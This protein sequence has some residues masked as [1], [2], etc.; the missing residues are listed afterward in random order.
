MPEKMLPNPIIVKVPYKRIDT[1]NVEEI[2]A[3][4]PIAKG[5]REGSVLEQAYRS[6]FSKYIEKYPTV[7]IVY[8]SLLE[9]GKNLYLSY[10]GETNNIGERTIQHLSGNFVA[11]F[12]DE[13][14]VG[15][16][17]LTDT[18]L[19]QYVI[20]NAHF[21]K[22]LTMD[23]ENKL[24]LYLSGADNV[25]RLFNARTNEQ[26]DYYTHDEFDRIFSQIWLTLHRDNP[27]LFPAE[28][29]IRD[30][31]LFK[32]SPFHE[33]TPSQLDAEQTILKVL[34][35]AH[36]GIGTQDRLTNSQQRHLILVQGGSGT[37]K[38]VL[39]SH[40]FNSV[41]SEMRSKHLDLESESGTTF[42]L[43]QGDYI[44]D[45][46]PHAYLLVNHDE[47]LNVY[48]QIADKLELQNSAN[49]RVLL[50]SQFI[51]RI[52]PICADS[53]VEGAD[54]VLVDEAHLLL[55]QGSQ[56]YRGHNMLLDIIKR[57]KVVI[58]VFDEHQ[59]LQS[60]QR[61]T[62]KQMSLLFPENR[63]ETVAIDEKSMSETLDFEQLT[64]AFA[65]S[66]DEAGT[67]NSSI[68]VEITRLHLREQ[69]RIAAS[70]DT[71][72]WIDNL[73]SGKG[74]SKIPED[75]WVNNHEEVS[76]ET[77]VEEPYEIRIFDSPVE[78]FKAIKIKASMQADGNQGKGLSR[79][80]A[81]YDWAYKGGREN[82][83]DCNKQWNVEL[84]RK[85][86]SWEMGLAD[87]D[88]FGY[89]PALENDSD[90][91]CYPWNYQIKQSGKGSRNHKYL[92]HNIAWAERHH[93]IDEI[94]STYTIQGFDL[95][96][97]GVIIGPSV[98]Y[99][100]GEIVFNAGN[101][102]NSKATNRRDGVLD[103]SE[104][105]LRNELNVL[106]KRGVH[107]LYIFAVDKELREALLEASAEHIEHFNNN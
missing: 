54:V 72:E 64:K 103:Y 66:P 56:G 86:S 74:I 82:T 17:K 30:S 50:P 85:G 42:K 18:Q 89:C 69:L 107:G 90:R 68:S 10:V 70:E 4:Q 53:N 28:Q 97:V 98:Q 3:N 41:T 35:S 39:L 31:A 21:N 55:T 105:N 81:T 79:V 6:L 36:F 37:G 51:R 71:I 93:T 99:R 33:L 23:V 14:N 101:S 88:N 16:A 13:Q 32:A 20:G 22:S 84:H 26:A 106:L 2:P 29:L 9:E 104:E 45:F 1:I 87:D 75:H 63:S 15:R 57:A 34:S 47:Q 44:G 11:Q 61:L 5:Y 27:E 46:F 80:V 76:K 40:L 58:I 92:N 49:R 94:G 24:M 62:E 19:Q 7:Y 52:A 8:Q 67:D 78:L 43:E 95:N 12:S 38:T 96:F 100:D 73:A 59:I 60:S 102:K 77:N 48:N 91:F 25:K 83:D 65:I